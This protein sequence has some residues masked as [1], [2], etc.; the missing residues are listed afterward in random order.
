MPPPLDPNS[1][2][3]AKRVKVYSSFAADI[4]LIADSDGGGDACRRIRVVT[5]GDVAFYCKDDP[6][7]LVVVTY[8]AGDVDDVQISKI[9]KSSD[10]T[11]ATKIAVYW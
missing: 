6:A 5:A 7:K 1:L 11:T 4:D 2:S 8:A 9:A 10:G 3:P